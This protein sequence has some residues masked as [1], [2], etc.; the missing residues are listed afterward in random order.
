MAVVVGELVQVVLV[1]PSAQGSWNCGGC[2]PMPREDDLGRTL[3]VA[4][5]YW[6]FEL[7][8]LV[9]E[10]LGHSSSPRMNTGFW[11]LAS[12]KSCMFPGVE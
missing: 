4:R 2:G 11:R 7:D 10:A 1:R 3:R 12:T 8:V 6:N 9:G 5:F